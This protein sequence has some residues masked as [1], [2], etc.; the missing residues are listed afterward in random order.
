MDFK[1]LLGFLSVCAFN[2][3]PGLPRVSSS[4]KSRVVG[5]LAVLFLES[6]EGDS[7]E[8]GAPL[9]TPGFRGR[10]VRSWPAQAVAAI[11]L[12]PGS[13]GRTPAHRYRDSAASVKLAVLDSSATNQP[14]TRTAVPIVTLYHFVHVAVAV[15]VQTVS[16]EPTTTTHSWLPFQDIARDLRHSLHPNTNNNYYSCYG[17][18][19]SPCAGLAEL[20]PE[21]ASH[22]AA[23]LLV[24]SI[25]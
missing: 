5:G 22:H 14:L 25:V 4:C 15:A 24:L 19:T 12:S 23:D 1:P 9:S 20:A 7:R 18:A 6:L 2:R 8:R 13:P 16:Q 17:L 3:I 10:S 21:F 11:K